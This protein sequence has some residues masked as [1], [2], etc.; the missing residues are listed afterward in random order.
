MPGSGTSI[1]NDPDDYQASL[2]WAQ[3]E[4]LVN[5]GDFKAR[6]TWAELHCLRLLR[7]EEHLPRIAYVSLVPTLTFVTFPSAADPPP[8]WGGVEVDTGK[9]MFHSRGERLHQWMRGPGLWNLIALPANDLRDY[10]RTLSGKAILAPPAGRVFRPRPRDAARLQR[11]HTQ[12]CRLAETKSKTLSHPQVARAIEEGLIQALVTCLT[13][14]DA[15]DDAANSRHRAQIMARF[16][17]AVKD[18]PN[19]PWHV[20]EICERIGVTDRTL[21]SCCAEFI[22]ISPSRYLLLRRLKQVRTALRNADP[23]NASVAELA[24]NHGFTELGRFAEIYRRAFGETPS[25]TLERMRGS[26]FLLQIFTD[27]A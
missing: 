19:R 8:V 14:S 2:R 13:T 15:R 9:I 4:L 3:M 5:S 10:G 18:N 11:L 27:S 7:G 12:A 25:A 23:A 1:F 22:G 6:L 17:E 20:S 16:E 26:G 24:R 21:R